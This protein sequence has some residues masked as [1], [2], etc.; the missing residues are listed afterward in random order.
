MKS[1]RERRNFVDARYEIEVPK[2]TGRNVPIAEIARAIGKDAQFVRI[3]LQQGIL[4]FGIAIKV[5][6]SSEYSYFCP[7]KKVWEETGY[8]RDEDKQ[9]EQE[10]LI[11]AKRTSEDIQ[12]EIDQ[13]KNR[14]K[15]VLAQEKT[16]Q[17]SLGRRD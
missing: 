16:G 5:G 9:A 12:R 13:L 7:D 10:D 2:F 8:F 1:F 15:E 17:E 14:K 3:G 11:M 6:S 4:K